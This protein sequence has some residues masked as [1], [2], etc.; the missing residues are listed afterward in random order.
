MSRSIDDHENIHITLD[1]PTPSRKDDVRRIDSEIVLR[2]LVYEIDTI[3]SD[4][5]L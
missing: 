1:P 2:R 4:F 3:V 5:G